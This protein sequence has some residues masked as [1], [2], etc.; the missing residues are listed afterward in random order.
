MSFIENVIKPTHFVGPFRGIFLLRTDILQT[1]FEYNIKKKQTGETFLVVIY[2]PSTNEQMDIIHLGIHAYIFMGGANLHTVA[3]GHIWDMGFEVYSWFYDFLLC[4]ST[5]MYLSSPKPFPTIYWRQCKTHFYWKKKS[6]LCKTW[7]CCVADG[8]FLS[9]ADGHFVHK[10]IHI[11]N[12]CKRGAYMHSISFFLYIPSPET[13]YE[14]WWCTIIVS[15][16][17]PQWQFWVKISFS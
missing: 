11:R 7:E 16:R 17:W 15:S 1:L 5:K 6:T 4:Y 14:W 10:F 2:S 8:H 12:P 3:D 13:V 9:V